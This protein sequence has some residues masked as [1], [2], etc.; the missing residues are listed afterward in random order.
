MAWASPTSSTKL[1]GHNRFRNSFFSTRCPWLS[2]SSKSVSYTLGAS[3]TGLPS[4]SSCFSAW[5]GQKQ[6]NLYATG[7]LD[8]RLPLLGNIVPIAGSHISVGKLQDFLKTSARAG[9]TI[10]LKEGND[11]EIKNEAIRRHHGE[12]TDSRGRAVFKYRTKRWRADGA[13]SRGARRG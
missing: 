11:H 9:A 4:R 12:R 7:T 6:P 8:I 10:G 1:P 3:G 5:W 13:T 2:S